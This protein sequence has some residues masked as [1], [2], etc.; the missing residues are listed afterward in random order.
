MFMIGDEFHRQL[1]KFSLDGNGLSYQ[2]IIS[3]AG[4]ES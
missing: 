4:K 1:N 2:E 3:Q